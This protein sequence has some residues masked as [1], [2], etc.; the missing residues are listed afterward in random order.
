MPSLTPILNDC[1]AWYECQVVGKYSTGD[2]IYFWGKAMAAMQ[3]SNQPPLREH[4]LFA[5]ANAT[6]KQLLIANKQ[7]DLQFHAPLFEQWL[8]QQKLQLENQ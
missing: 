6:T 2:R 5:A 8:A 4:D 3:H 7:A 1:L